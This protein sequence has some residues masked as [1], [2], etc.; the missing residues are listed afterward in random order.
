MEE[1]IIDSISVIP[2]G[3]HSRSSIDNVLIP[4]R[5]RKE[6]RTLLKRA[7]RYGYL[8]HHQWSRVN[9][10]NIYSKLCSAHNLIPIFCFHDNEKSRI[11]V[12]HLSLEQ[13]KKTL[14]LLTS[15]ISCSEKKQEDLKTVNITLENLNRKNAKKLCDKIAR[16]ISK[17]NIMLPL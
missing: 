1:N 15:D 17:Q 3:K 9:T 11:T 14:E 13:K 12:E 8:E 16:K 5:L 7:M 4:L 6:E 2:R 10:I